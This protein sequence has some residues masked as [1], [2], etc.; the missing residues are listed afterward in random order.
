[1]PTPTKETIDKLANYR[2]YRGWMWLFAGVTVVMM[3]MAV[4]FSLAHREGF[5]LFMA[6]V[7]VI[8]HYFAYAAR[9]GARAALKD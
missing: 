6:A 5:S 1:M 4:G 7:S 3:V 8:P 2:W 9:D